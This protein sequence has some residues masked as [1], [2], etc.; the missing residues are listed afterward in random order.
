MLFITGSPSGVSSGCQAAA[1]AD[2][3][4]TLIAP[5]AS[6]VDQSDLQGKLFDAVFRISS[7]ASP[8]WSDLGWRHRSAASA[9]GGAPNRIRGGHRYCKSA[10][11]VDLYA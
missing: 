4:A 9:S 3:I 8:N 6:S 1:P 11:V 2:G 10:D 5:A 7:F